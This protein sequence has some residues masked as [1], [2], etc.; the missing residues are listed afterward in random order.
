L[1]FWK[2]GSDYHFLTRSFQKY[3]NINDGNRTRY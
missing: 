2:V 3:T 1:T